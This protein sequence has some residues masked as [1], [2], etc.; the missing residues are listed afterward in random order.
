MSGRHRHHSK[1]HGK[2]GHFKIQNKDNSKHGQ[3]E[4][5]LQT[6]EY[7][8]DFDDYPEN[9]GPEYSLRNFEH[10]HHGHHRHEDDFFTG[11]P[12]KHGKKDKFGK[13]DKH[14]KH[15]PYP[16]TIGP[17]Y[18][19]HSFDNLNP[20]FSS[21]LSYSS[22]DEKHPK[23]PVEID[24]LDPHNALKFYKHGHR[25][26]HHQYPYAFGPEYTLHT[27]DH[28]RRLSISSSSS[29]S[30]NSS[31]SSS[32]SSASLSSTP[33]QKF[34]HLEYS[35]EHEQL[36]PRNAIK[37]L[38]NRHRHHHH[39]HNPYSFGPN[40]SL[41]PYG[42]YYPNQD[43]SSSSESESSESS[44][45]SKSSSSSSSS[46]SESSSTSSASSSATSI[47]SSSSKGKKQ[48][49]KTTENDPL[50]PD[51]TNESSMKEESHPFG[52][53]PKYQFELEYPRMPESFEH[54]F[55][56][57]YPH[58]M[59]YGVHDFHGHRGHHHHHHKHFFHKVYPKMDFNE[60]EKGYYINADLP[61]M[62]LDDVKIETN[63]N[64]F[65]VISGERKSAFS[66]SE[67]NK[68]SEV[69]EDNDDKKETKE[70]VTKIT[71]N[72]CFEGKFERSVF[73]PENG[74]LENMKTKMNNGV[75]EIEIK[76]K[77]NIN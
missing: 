57:G 46:E 2:H 45:S 17:E 58:F 29:S 6:V 21:S 53:N 66:S 1:S 43:I 71:R 28:H 24:P 8:L 31:S 51:S 35:F 63:E 49:E 76:K 25:H 7:N 67:S 37:S 44:E 15:G 22:E 59:P 47:S 69:V 50:N 13:K 64:H 14:G 65:V 70:T 32:A 3:K 18:T 40:Y 20:E 42:Y 73:I 12:P 36:N 52:F 48:S 74:D 60:T 27:F 61:G 38:K 4:Y 41:N 33:S 54:N 34:K 77:E 72:E 62:T 39:H 11:K 68:V 10:L 56:F 55:G 16:Y 9:Y 23:K 30:S 5:G 19:L 26:H 75:L